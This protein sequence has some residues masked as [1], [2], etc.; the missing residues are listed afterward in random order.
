MSSI[1][2]YDLKSLETTLKSKL[3]VLLSELKFGD[4]CL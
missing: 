4:S 2:K 1:D 3:D